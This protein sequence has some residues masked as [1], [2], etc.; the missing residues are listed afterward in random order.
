MSN[1]YKVGDFVRII[2]GRENYNKLCIHSRD[3]L[4]ITE[5]SNYG[6]IVLVLSGTHK[7]KTM[8]CN[9]FVLCHWGRK[10]N[11]KMKKEI[12]LWKLKK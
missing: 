9:D 3:T 4:Y 8:Y 6:Y 7:G 12:I 11:K 10:P 5:N 2:K 1:M